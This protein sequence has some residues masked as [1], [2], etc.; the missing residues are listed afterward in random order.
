MALRMSNT[1]PCSLVSNNSFNFR[2]STDNRNYGRAPTPKLQFIWMC[3]TPV[4]SPGQSCRIVRLI[5][6]H[7]VN[8]ASSHALECQ[9]WQPGSHQGITSFYW[10]WT[11]T[12]TRWNLT[13]SSIPTVLRA[14]LPRSDRAKLM[15]LPATRSSP[16]ISNRVAQK[17][18]FSCE[19]TE[20]RLM[21]QTWSAFIDCDSVAFLC[22]VDSVQ[23]AH[24]KQKKPLF[25]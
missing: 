19:K 20:N 16:R 18:V 8:E 1:E 6:G 24:L 21:T 13:S 22:E 7:C 5:S 10:R 17:E 23:R 12:S 4:S 2:R 11:T 9:T 3:G 25:F 14:F 15:L